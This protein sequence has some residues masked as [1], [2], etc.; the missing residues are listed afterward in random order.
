M[1]DEDRKISQ[2]PELEE[3]PGDNDLIV[4]VHEGVTSKMTFAQLVGPTGPTGPAGPTGPTGPTGPVGP[5]GA[6][7][8]NGAS[9]AY[10][11][12]PLPI[13]RG[14]VNG[15]ASYTPPTSRHNF[16]PIR[17]PHDA[18]LVFSGIRIFIANYWTSSGAAGVSLY[19]NRSPLTNT[20]DLDEHVPMVSI[21]SSAQIGFMDFIFSVPKTIS[22]GASAQIDI[23]ANGA[24][25]IGSAGFAF[26]GSA[27]G[28]IFSPG[29]GGI[30][31]ADYNASTVTISSNP[32]EAPWYELIA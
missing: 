26:L 28:G 12:L 19:R 10:S 11:P 30:A 9:S 18:D 5:T 3:P 23:I 22:A 25:T 2:L 20:Y 24:N 31:A 17:A 4:V 21:T 16:M 1:A 32:A 14:Q 7:G 8:A 29:I 13:M 6:T 27:P 15:A